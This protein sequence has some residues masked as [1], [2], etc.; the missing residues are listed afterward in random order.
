[1][2]ARALCRVL[3]TKRPAFPQ[4]QSLSSDAVSRS[5]EGGHKNRAR[6]TVM[7]GSCLA[8]TAQVQ[9]AIVYRLESWRSHLM[10]RS[11]S[12]RQGGRTKPVSSQPTA[13]ASNR[14]GLP[15]PVFQLIVT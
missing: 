14:L 3:G 9:D 5:A 13:V 12:S 7:R 11:I 10:A 6:M 4:T 8:L 1:M 2:W 15:R